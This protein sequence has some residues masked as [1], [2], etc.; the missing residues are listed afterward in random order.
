MCPE[1]GGVGISDGDLARAA[2]ALTLAAEAALERR[3]AAAATVKRLSGL[4]R[5]PARKDQLEN[6]TSWKDVPEGTLPKLIIRNIFEMGIDNDEP[7]ERM[8]EVFPGHVV[9]FRCA[10]DQKKP[11]FPPDGTIRIRNIK[12]VEA[13][14]DGFDLRLRNGVVFHL[15]AR[16]QRR[17]V[18]VGRWLETLEKLVVQASEK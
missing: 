1:C 8:F 16:A 10:K 6:H 4:A 5:P 3:D 9:Y 13:F 15:R 14:E 17:D 11:G 2:Q 12:D 18:D 7:V